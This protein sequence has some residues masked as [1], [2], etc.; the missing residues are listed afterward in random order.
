[1][2]RHLATETLFGDLTVERWLLQ[3]NGLNVLLVPDAASDTIAYHTYF[4]VGSGD[5]VQGKTGLAHLFEHMMF[6][7]T[8]KY[9]DQHFS[10]VIEEAGGP[11]LN[12]WTWLDITAYHVSLPKDQLAMIA[13]LEATRMDGLVIDQGQLDS[14]REVVLNE[15]RYRV[16]NSPEGAMSERLWALAFQTNRYHWPTIGWAED[17]EGYEVADL[18]AFYKAYYAPN[19][20]TVVLAGGFDREEAL[21]ILGEAYGAIPSSELP[22]LPHGEEAPQTEL[23]RLDMEQPIEAEMLTWGFKVP[24]LTHPDHPALAVADA[25]LSGGSATR[26]Q[27]RLVDSGLAASAGAWLPPF[28][29]EA[30]YE[31]G[32]TMRPGQGAAS[33]IAV[34][35][36]ELADLRAN[37]VSVE[38]LERARNQLLSQSYGELLSNSGRAGFVGFNEVAAGHWKTGI[39]RI[40]AYRTVTAADVQRVTAAYLT[41]ERSSLVVARP[42]NAAVLPPA[43]ELPPRLEE[44]EPLLPVASR[45]RAGVPDLPLGQVVATDQG[46]WERLLVRDPTVPMVWFR[47]ALADG[48]SRDPAGKEGLANLTA[49]LLLRG[50]TRRSRDVF[51]RTLEGLGASVDA[52]VDADGITLSG[53]VLAEN[54]PQTAALLT[55]AVAM[56]RFGEEDFEDLVDEIEAGIIED[57]NNDRWLGRRAFSEVLW[58]AH[59]YARPVEGTPTSLH[60]ITRDDVVAFHRAWF[61]RTGA[62][63]ALLGDFD[64]P[65]VAELDRIVGAL[66]AAPSPPQ[67]RPALVPPVG[68]SVTL[69]DKPERTQLQIHLGH[70][71]PRPQGAGFAAARVAGEAFGGGGFGTRLMHEVREVRGWSYGAYG[72]VGH[73]RDGS[74]YLMWVFPA[75]DDAIPCLK[76]VLDLYEQFVA[77]GITADEL[78]YAKSSIVNSAAFFTDTPGKRL[79]Y[80]VRKRRTGYDPLALMPLIEQVTLEQANAAAKVAFD[81]ANLAGSVVGTASTPVPMDAGEGAEAKPLV[82]ALRAVIGDRVTV[83]PFDQE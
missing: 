27:R 23:R 54:W 21:R 69:V 34:V 79:S 12:A 2:F 41:L 71:F 7:R 52:V 3:D 81:P 49:E 11:D 61:G 24:P 1:M 68:R 5:E 33:A 78:R 50:T 53:S 75:N 51:E 80:E 32:V 35:E 6:K 25:I 62:L 55:E 20:A 82:E 14:E 26:L 37:L 65:A 60:A 4:D 70:F 45:S 58:G 31:V 28:Q 76:L 16:D 72:S 57:R 47:V 38:E 40:E 36:Q 83:V 59:P 63:A 44:G 15:R 73:S 13:D 67:L 17:I 22:R 77:T 18:Q 46:G 9:D 74:S 42:K 8:D 64:A 19:N 39:E 66:G 30:L 48:S 10:R 43:D 29:H 56:P